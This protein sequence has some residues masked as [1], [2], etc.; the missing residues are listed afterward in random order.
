MRHSQRGGTLETELYFDGSCEGNGTPE[1][2][3]FWAWVAKQGGR[4]L[5]RGYGAVDQALPQ[6]NNTG[7][8]SALLAGLAALAD[9]RARGQELGAVI[10]KGDSQLIINQARGVWAVGA[11]HLAPL[12]KRARDLA[13]ALGVKAWQWIPRGDNWEADALTRGPHRARD[14]GGPQGGGTDAPAR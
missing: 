2:R 12:C 13:R 11:A 9:L 6:T 3:A 8:Y 4:D 7:E 1:A 10:V 5:A 14:G